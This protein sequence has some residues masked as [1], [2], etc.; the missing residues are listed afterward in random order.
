MEDPG[1]SDLAHF[2]AWLGPEAANGNRPRPEVAVAYGIPGI[3][4]SRLAQLRQTTLIILGR[5]SRA[6]ER[7]LLL[8]ETGDAVVRRSDQP[9]LF[10]PP[11]VGQFHRV[12]V[13]IDGTER[14]VRVLEMAVAVTR[15]LAA[16]LTAITV[17]PILTD[18]EPVVSAPLPRGR[19]FRLGDA[20]R[21]QPQL[22]GVDI[23]LVTRRGNPIEEVLGYASETRPDLLVI[24]YRRGGQPK[25]VG[26]TEI[27][28]NLLYAAPCAVFTV[29]L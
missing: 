9:V 10:V 5:R 2:V 6:P 27:A 18:E 14:S 25:V 15:S 12:L 13:A 4:I 11:G 17:D 22:A 3:E 1:N 24:G 19:A 7:R 20:L 26:P 8:G 28:R 23:P 29:P 16:S 21:K